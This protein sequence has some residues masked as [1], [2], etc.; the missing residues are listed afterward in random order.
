[1][2]DDRA[3]LAFEIGA[4]LTAGHGAEAI[5][6][7]L[8]RTGWRR[9]PARRPMHPLGAVGLIAL[10][11][12]VVAAVFLDW[13]WA[14]VGL[15]ALIVCAAIGAA[16]KEATVDD[17][18]AFLRARLDEDEQAANARPL[19]GHSLRW[20]ALRVD[21]PHVGASGRVQDRPTWC[22]Y[23]DERSNA[24]VAETTDILPL[25]V[26]HIARHDPARVL[27]DVAAKRQ[28]IEFWSLAYRNPMDA[29]MFAGLDWDR[30]RSNGQWTLRLL[31][32]PDA[33]HPDYREEWRP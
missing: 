8:I 1:V 11:V 17:L 9:T 28:I 31:A 12:G 20:T 10:A 26:E 16:T 2:A 4:A 30:V 24:L 7:H 33:D 18:I 3:D 13:R 22:V 23:T 21:R 15:A 27:A 32:L 25:V 29:A 6:D 5:A 19:A 14:I